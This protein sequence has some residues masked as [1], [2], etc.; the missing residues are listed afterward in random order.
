ME[1]GELKELRQILGRA[2]FTHL[3]PTPVLEEILP[4]FY[5]ISFQ[6]GERVIQRGSSAGAFI[7]IASGKMDVIVQNEKGED[8]VLKTL[9]PVDYV[10]EM[11]L[12]SGS[13]R[14]ATIITREQVKAYLLGK[15]AFSSLLEAVPEVKEFFLKVAERRQKDVKKSVLDIEKGTQCRETRKG[16][17]AKTPVKGDSRGAGS[18]SRKKTDTGTKRRKK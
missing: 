12:L 9:V 4:K 14:N 10:G 1:P 16:A 2:D 18:S 13:T 5:P 3:V 15:A 11:A 8:F 6:E 17:S 7:I